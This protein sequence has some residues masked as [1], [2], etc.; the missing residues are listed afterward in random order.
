MVKRRKDKGQ[1]SCGYSVVCWL[2][3]LYHLHELTPY[4][5][6]KEGYK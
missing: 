2:E 5:Q 4:P 3:K 1:L 6:S